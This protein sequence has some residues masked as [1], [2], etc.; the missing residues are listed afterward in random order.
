MRARGRLAHPRVPAGLCHNAEPR[1]SVGTATWNS[2]GHG[3]CKQYSSARQ[4]VVLPSKVTTLTLSHR[5][6][7]GGGDDR[8]IVVR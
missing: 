8:T 3:E 1:G 4:I 6:R 5:E 7:P 2:A